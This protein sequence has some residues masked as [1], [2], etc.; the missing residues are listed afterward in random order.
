MAGDFSRDFAEDFVIIFG[1]SSNTW[2]M[3]SNW[4][5]ALARTW[6]QPLARTWRQVA[7]GGPAYRRAV[8]GDTAA[9]FG[10]AGLGDC[11]LQL[12][13][14]AVEPAAFDV[15]R[16][17]AVTVF[18]GG[19]VGV[20]CHHLYK[21]YP[22]LLGPSRP[23][24][25][26]LLDNVHCGLLYIPAYFYGVGL[27]QGDGLSAV[28]ANLR[29][30]WLETYVS[31]SAFWV[32]VMWITFRVVPAPHQVKAVSVGSCIWAVFIDAIA[33]RAEDRAEDSDSS[34]NAVD[35]AV[36]GAAPQMRSSS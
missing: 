9:S 23:L 4:R 16:F 28:R 26:A 25:C 27:L 31:C 5:A 8:L 6:R 13:V 18:T 19:Y 29:R 11:V 34:S 30:Q 33:H 15:R 35:T 21:V 10:L 32:P 12:G 24:A 3:A 14:E 36:V 7:P 2:Q 22:L 20:L 1:Q 17:G